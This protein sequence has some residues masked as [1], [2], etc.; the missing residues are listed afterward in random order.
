MLT[1][2]QHEI[3][4]RLPANT[5]VYAAPGSGKTTVLTQHIA[6]MLTRKILRPQQMMAMTFTRQAAIDMKNRLSQVDELLPRIIEAVQMGTFHAQVFRML[7]RHEPNIP[8]LLSSLEQD[9]M[10]RYAMR[11]AGIRSGQVQQWQSTI[12]KA[13]A[14]WPLQIPNRAVRRVLNN[15]EQMKRYH[16]RWDFDDILLSFCSVFC[17]SDRIRPHV[18]LDYLLVDEYQDTNAVQAQIVTYFAKQLKTPVFVVGDDDQAIYGFRGASPKWL[19]DFKTSYPHVGEFGLSMNFRS[20][21]KIFQH[22]ALLIGHN[23]E[24]SPKNVQIASTNQGTCKALFSRDEADEAHQILRILREFQ[25]RGTVAVLAR[26]RRQLL[27]VWRVLHD[28]CPAIQFRTFHDAK[29]KEW[30]HV[31]VV[32]CIEY[33]PYLPEANP[34]ANLEEERRLMYVAMTRA[35]CRL[36]IHTPM[37]VLGHKTA[38]SRFIKEAGLQQE[39]MDKF[40]YDS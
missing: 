30:D 7:L 26:T 28:V 24:R 18:E 19:L 12:A 3:V 39:W 5:V 20:D 22:A 10:L 2:E 37:R 14:Q 25:C 4:V 1:T 23:Q 13:K 15:Y 35:R 11:S 33:N 31:H 9:R 36:F 38:P 16:H 17:T 32:G 40:K 34:R 6:G 27:S 21:Q 8:L 29:G